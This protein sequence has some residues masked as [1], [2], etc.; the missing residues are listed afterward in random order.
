MQTPV[1]I[2]WHN[3][4]PIPHIAKLIDDRVQRMEKFFGRI[5]RCRV[6]VKAPAPTL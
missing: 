3:M 6:M 5:T 1:E 2:T 4:D